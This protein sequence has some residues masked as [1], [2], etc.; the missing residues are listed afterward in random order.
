MVNGSHVLFKAKLSCFRVEAAPSQNE[1]L[2][3]CNAT[4]VFLTPP[5]VW[6]LLRQASWVSPILSCPHSHLM[7]H[8][9]ELQQPT[10][11]YWVMKASRTLPI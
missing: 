3:V 2:W 11:Q 9:P 5:L 4:L 1:V 6:N 10:F 8:F 7:C